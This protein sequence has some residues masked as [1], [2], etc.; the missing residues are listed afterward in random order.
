MCHT[1][2]AEPRQLQGSCVAAAV[3]PCILLC[4]QV[5][6]LQGDLARLSL[7]WEEA[8]HATLSE[9]QVTRLSVLGSVL[10]SDCSASAL[11]FH[12]SCCEHAPLCD[13]STDRLWGHCQDCWCWLT[14]CAASMA[15][16]A[17]VCG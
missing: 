6:L 17:A 13:S 15:C 9:L 14:M 10:T 11:T 7:L 4:G 3:T 12:C 16:G 1:K 5:R 8:W 2:A